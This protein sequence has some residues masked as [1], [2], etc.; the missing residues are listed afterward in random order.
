[1]PSVLNCRPRSSFILVTF[2]LMGS[3]I[4]LLSNH[5]ISHLNSRCFQILTVPQPRVSLR[6]RHH[7]WPTFETGRRKVAWK[8]EP[9]WSWARSHRIGLWQV[10]FEEG[11]SESR[12]WFG[13]F[14]ESPGT[15]IALGILEFGTVGPRLEQ[16]WALK[17][18]R[19]S[20]SWA[21]FGKSQCFSPTLLWCFFDH[22]TTESIIENPGLF[23]FFDPSP[24]CTPEIQLNRWP[25]KLSCKSLSTSLDQVCTLGEGKTS[26]W[27]SSCFSSSFLSVPLYL[28]SNFATSG[29]IIMVCRKFCWNS[30]FLAHVEVLYRTSQ[31]YLDWG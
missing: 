22:F 3:P 10:A 30:V 26:G 4:F 29:S 24:I 15:L 1:M 21:G 2:N 18:A 11:L 19:P 23:Y 25:K 17:T 7:S 31:Q 27:G 5:Q 28:N 9:S 14:F 12:R 16:C 8:S 13:Q 6:P 20:A